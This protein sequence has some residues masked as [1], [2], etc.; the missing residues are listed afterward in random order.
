MVRVNHA[1][2]ETIIR[3][4]AAEKILP[5]FR[6]LSSSDVEEKS[7][8]SLVT[9][10]DKEAEE[11]L[12]VALKEALPGSVVVGEETYAANPQIFDLFLNDTPLWIVDP[13]DGTSNFVSGDPNFGVMVALAVKDELVASWIYHPASDEFVAAEVHNGAFYKGNRVHALPAV[14]LNTQLGMFYDDTVLEATKTKRSQDP[15][16]S[17]PLF[18]CSHEYPRLILDGYHFGKDM[19]QMHFYGMGPYATPWDLASGVL[20]HTE[21]G[22]FSAFWNEEPFSLRAFPRMYKTPY[23]F[24][25]SKEA[26]VELKKWIQDET[27]FS[28]N[29]K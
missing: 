24:A 10:A 6:H 5:R 27:S 9:V 3:E 20:V 13:I 1:M 18:A 7:D 15:S 23:L 25:S 21:A 12:S 16:F 17:V 29:Q 28:F 2:I 19:P 8:A 14:E 11:T 4:V 22:G 26:W